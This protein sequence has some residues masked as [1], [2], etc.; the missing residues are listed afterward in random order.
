MRTRPYSEVDVFS[1]EPYRGNALAVVH[2]ADGLSAE[3]MQRFAA[4]TNLSETTFLLP[5]SSPEADYR[6]RIFTGKEELPFAG[7]PTLGT[8]RA[9]L[10]AGGRP[11]V[12]GTVRQECAAGLIPVR[13]DGDSLA[14]QAPPLTRYGPVDE[15]LI[16]RLADILGIQREKILAA[17]W[18]VNGPQWIGVRLAS[19]REVLDLQPDPGKAGELEIGVVGP[20]DAAGEA[21]FEVR[22]FV[23]GDPVW[24]DPVTGS[25]NA[26]L[27]QW[28]TDTA[29][30]AP[31]YTASQGTVLGRRGRVHISQRDGK[32]WVGGHVTSCIKGTVRL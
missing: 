12:D 14:F 10:D 27:G 2:D 4:W 21:A 3:Q 1:D 18:L 9:W 28:L 16:R 20:Y 31:P 22:A 5:P 26:G 25:L 23:G 8:A 24:E 29:N 6:V 30:A 7:H 19:A 15:P 13:A 11:G 32:I 17:S